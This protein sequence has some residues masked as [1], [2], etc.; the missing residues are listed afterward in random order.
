M[1]EARRAAL[2]ID[3]LEEQS[4]SSGQVKHLQD[5]VTLF[6]N[7]LSSFNLMRNSVMSAAIGQAVTF[8]LLLNI[9]YQRCVVCP[10]VTSCHPL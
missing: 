5:G 8:F 4:E 2:S 9:K 7:I 10:S 6:V 3:G 1:K